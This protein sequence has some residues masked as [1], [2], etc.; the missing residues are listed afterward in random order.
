MTNVNR[1][2]VAQRILDRIQ[3]ERDS[4]NAQLVAQQSHQ[5]A[6]ALVA[7]HGDRAVE[8]LINNYCIDVVGEVGD[9]A[10]G[11]RRRTLEQAVGDA[12]LTSYD[13]VRLVIQEIA[14]EFEDVLYLRGLDKKI[15]LWRTIA[16][17]N[18]SLALPEGTAPPAL[19][20]G[21]T[22][23]L[24]QGE[25]NRTGTPALPP[26]EATPTETDPNGG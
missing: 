1:K 24:T 2:S 4:G 13:R 26:G 20:E 7:L 22:P 18:R 25:P 17:A 14:G 6:S 3:R 15:E 10:A 8:E 5:W 19:P 21:R 16:E 12:R 9:A 23:E 11:A